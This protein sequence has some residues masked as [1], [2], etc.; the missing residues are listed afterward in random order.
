[1]FEEA[2]AKAKELWDNGKQKAKDFYAEH[3]DACEYL[4][5]IVGFGTVF[6]TGLSVG[7]SIEQQKAEC[8]RRGINNGL[9]AG[10]NIYEK[11]LQQANRKE[12][13]NN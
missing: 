2:K 13:E 7:K 10:S 6:G 3:P 11:A 5:G 12:D 8:W 9:N 1:M 4:V